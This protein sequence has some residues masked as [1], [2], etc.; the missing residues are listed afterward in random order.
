MLYFDSSEVIKVFYFIGY[1]SRSYFT[2]RFQ[3]NFK[4]MQ[5]SVYSSAI[6]K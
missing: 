5:L 3:I 4:R 2:L 1:I 6:K